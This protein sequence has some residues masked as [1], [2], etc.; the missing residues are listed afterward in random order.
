MQHSQTTLYPLY[1]VTNIVDAMFVFF[2]SYCNL[3]QLAP[4]YVIPSEDKMVSLHDV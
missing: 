1:Q 4:T 3:K 2:V